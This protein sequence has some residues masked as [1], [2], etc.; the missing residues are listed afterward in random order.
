MAT[1]L[2]AAA[3][4]NTS[5]DELN[6]WSDSAGCSGEI[7]LAIWELTADADTA[8]RI[9]Q[10]PT[11]AEFDA[12]TTRAWELADADDTELHWGLET[13]RRPA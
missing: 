6:R 4:Q 13:I 7:A 11:P 5:L 3:Q 9:W 12:V 10:D 1:F 2:T 8:D